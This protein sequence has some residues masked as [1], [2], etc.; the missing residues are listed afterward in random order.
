MPSIAQSDNT[1]PRLSRSSDVDPHMANYSAISEGARHSSSVIHEGVKLFD[2][3]INQASPWM[4]N[5]EQNKEV[6]ATESRYFKV[7]EKS[8]KQDSI[9]QSQSVQPSGG[10]FDYVICRQHQN[11]RGR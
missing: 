5:Q 4:V 1:T 8:S 10:T 9:V 2:T 6:K 7:P 3:S 11:H